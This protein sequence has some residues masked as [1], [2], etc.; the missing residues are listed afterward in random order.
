MPGRNDVAGGSGDEKFNAKSA[1]ES[2]AQSNSWQR[3]A[4]GCYEAGH[5]GTEER[6]GLATTIR[7]SKKRDPTG[8]NNPTGPRAANA[9]GHSSDSGKR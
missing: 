4:T 8:S 2:H 9:S 7:K 6:H 3:H 1:P 5:D